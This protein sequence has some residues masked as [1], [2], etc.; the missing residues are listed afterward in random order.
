ME[1]E[2]VD[3]PVSAYR[4]ASK[5]LEELMIAALESKCSADYAA[6]KARKINADVRRKAWT[7]IAS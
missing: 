7:G 4:C 2:A 5:E 1:I 6:K 3:D